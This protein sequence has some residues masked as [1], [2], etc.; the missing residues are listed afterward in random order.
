MIANLEKN[1]ATALLELRRRKD[2]VNSALFQNYVLQLDDDYSGPLDTITSNTSGA[3]NVPSGSAEET[4]EN[5]TVLT[6]NEAEYLSKLLCQQLSM[7][8][9][10]ETST[11]AGEQEDEEED[12]GQSEVWTKAINTEK[13]LREELALHKRLSRD[14]WK[15]PRTL[16]NLIKL[17]LRL[18]K[19]YSARSSAVRILRALIAFKNATRG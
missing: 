17:L 19:L 7:R 13:L 15:S 2:W 3:P 11:D 16:R 14:V 4:K 12:E 10:N 9:L 5:R 1:K 8:A 18:K 6:A